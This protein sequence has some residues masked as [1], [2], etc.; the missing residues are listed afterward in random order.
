[1][2]KFNL[3]EHTKYNP[4]DPEQANRVEVGWTAAGDGVVHIATCTSIPERLQALA[5]AAAEGSDWQGLCICLDRTQIN[6]L[7]R[8]LRR[9]RDAAYGR[10]E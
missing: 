10:D 5:T 8:E 9:A 6:A 1:M 4:Q 2:P 3:Y 7:I